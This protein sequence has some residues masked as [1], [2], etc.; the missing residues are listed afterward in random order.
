MPVN[1]NSTVGLVCVSFAYAGIDC[2]DAWVTVWLQSFDRIIRCIFCP[3]VAVSHHIAS[4][5]LS[6]CAPPNQRPPF[7]SLLSHFSLHT[8]THLSRVG[9]SD[10]EKKEKKKR[11][12][13]KTE[14]I[15]GTHNRTYNDRELI[16][17]LVFYRSHSS[18]KFTMKK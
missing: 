18:D 9:Y 13:K 10:F 8:H 16:N 1:K 4:S 17:T 11:K 7:T 5:S 12:K 3:H 14:K 2:N 6:V 15:N